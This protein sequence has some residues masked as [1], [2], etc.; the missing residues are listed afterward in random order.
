M[1][2][3]SPLLLVLAAFL[4]TAT[5]QF[6]FFDQMFGGGDGQQQQQQRQQP[7][8]PSDSTIY[9]QNFESFTCDNYLCPDTLANEDK[10]ETTDGHRL[11]VSKGGFKA[12]EAMRK[13]ELARKGM[14]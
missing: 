13:V 10:V 14:L 5:A 4:S 3:F 7:N 2:T 11:C 12:G 1:R 8:V 6:G 9:R